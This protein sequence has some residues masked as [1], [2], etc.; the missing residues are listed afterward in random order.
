MSELKFPTEVIELPSKGLLYPADHPLAK[1]SV[2]MKYMTAR[3]EDILTNPNYIEKG[4]VVEKLLESL[5]IT[6]VDLNEFFVGDK[7]AIMLAARILG[8][9][10]DYTFNYN[11]KSYTVDLSKLD[12]KPLD[13]NIFSE[14]NRFK[15]TLPVSG[16]EVVFKL[17]SEKDETKID[18]EVTGL[19]KLNK[20]SNPTITTRLK[21][22]ILSV[23]GD[24]DRTNIKNFVDNYL[25]AADSRA[26][27][28]YALSINPD[29]ETK[30]K[31]VNSNGVEEDVDLP[32][33]I[34]FF[35]PDF[36]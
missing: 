22:M 2:E 19:K 29:V 18:E 3:E 15:F 12:A 30:F 20:D 1:G 33:G 16:N 24:E 8:Y 31:A 17:L 10:K 4:I 6:K 21:H 5:L 11:G 7:N 36:E 32:I 9:G 23:N 27:R 26:L 35:Y 14:R 13:P 25:L 34:T 28:N